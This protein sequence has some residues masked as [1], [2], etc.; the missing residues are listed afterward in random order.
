MTINDHQMTKFLVQETF[1]ETIQGEGYWTG[2]VVD[3]IRLYGCPVRCPYCDTG[4]ADGGKFV[5]RSSKTIEELIAEL[6]SPRVV[7]SGGEPFLNK[8]LP[9]L[10]QAIRSDGRTISIE[11]SGCNYQELPSIH[12]I[13]LSPKEYVSPK[14]PVAPEMWTCANEVKIVISTG[15]E[16]EF[17]RENLDKKSCPIYLQPEWKERDRTIPLTLNLLRK[18]PIAR[19]SLQTHKYIGVS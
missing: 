1:Q 19:L 5:E 11:T 8:N 14:Y 3:F 7:I 15:K 10:V 16:L 9:E 12:W 4:Y 17:Y 18:Y 13:T 6:R 2:T